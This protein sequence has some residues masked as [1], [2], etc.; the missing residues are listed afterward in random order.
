MSA[1]ALPPHAAEARKTRPGRR[2]LVVIIAVLLIGLAVIVGWLT[3]RAGKVNSTDARIAAHVIAVSSEV[4]G[5]VVDLQ[6]RAGQ[7]LSLI[8]I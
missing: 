5:R 8:H 3:L 1:D 4:S 7:R 6:V 2:K